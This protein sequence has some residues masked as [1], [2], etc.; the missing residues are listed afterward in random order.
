M[1]TMLTSSVCR[2]SSCLVILCQLTLEQK[3]S[4]RVWMVSVRKVYWLGLLLWDMYWWQKI[5]LGAMNAF[6]F[7]ILSNEMGTPFQLL[8]LHSELW[9]L[10]RGKLLTCLGNLR[11]EVLIFL[12]Q[13]N[14]PLVKQHRNGGPALLCSLGEGILCHSLK[15]PA[16]KTEWSKET[17]VYTLYVR[18]TP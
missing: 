10:S 1:C 7:S 15:T 11:E 14:S 16:F 2:R 4:L 12:M 18:I 8:L 3:K 5:K 6:L 9:S 13:I 17:K